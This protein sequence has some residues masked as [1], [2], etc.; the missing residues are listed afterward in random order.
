MHRK[1]SKC[2]KEAFG[3]SSRIGW[4]RQSTCSHN[5]V[6]FLS[7]LH[8]ILAFMFGRLLPSMLTYMAFVVDGG[9]ISCNTCL[10]I[11]LEPISTTTKRIFVEVILSA[12]LLA[13]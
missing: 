11:G 13:E 7:C 4:I 3:E 5:T 9:D 12:V 10:S 2:R 8:R 1:A 6:A